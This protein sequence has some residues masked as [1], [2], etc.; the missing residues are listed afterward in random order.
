[1]VEIKNL[2]LKFNP[3]QLALIKGESGVGK[4][5]LINLLLRFYDPQEGSIEIAQQNIKELKLDFRKHISVCSQTQLFFNDSIINNLRV[6]NISK[7]F[8]EGENLHGQIR[9]SEQ[10][11]ELLPRQSQPEEEIET[12]CRELGMMD[13]IESLENKWD[14]KVGENGQL[15]S[16]G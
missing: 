1:M 13:K 4:T 12:L 14:F 2:N 15:L 10:I 7:Y 9:S 11:R 6:A 16:G 3:G 5:T 8:I